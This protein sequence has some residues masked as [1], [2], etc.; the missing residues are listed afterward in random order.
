MKKIVLAVAFVL[1]GAVGVV[2]G[3]NTLGA[4]DFDTTKAETRNVAHFTKL[5][6]EAAGEIYITQGAESSVTIVADKK[7]RDSIKTRVDGDTLE[8]Y[9]D[10][11][12]F[13][14]WLSWSD[15]D[16]KDL[17]IY[18]TITDLTELEF[19]GVGK[20]EGENLNLRSLELDFSGVGDVTLTG[21]VNHIDI[22]AE[23]VGR[24]DLS[25]F[26]A[27]HVVLEQDGIGDVVVYASESL[28]I[29]ASG[30]G[31]VGYMGPVEKVTVSSRGL[32]GV[33][34]ID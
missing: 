5:E 27:D 3:G 18:I 26:H 19:E 17:Q 31:K 16:E 25:E 8:I 1:A 34:R 30:I 2:Y 21:T 4:T 22:D 20:V 15:W 29:D 14:R 6:I 12:F 24:L 7:W 23:G 33:S 28:R 9:A 10:Y 13:D 11:G 32:G